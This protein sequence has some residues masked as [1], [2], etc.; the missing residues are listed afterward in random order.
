VSDSDPVPAGECPLCRGVKFYH[1]EANSREAEAHP[2]SPRDGQGHALVP[3]RICNSVDTR[4]RRLQAHLASAC[5]LKGEELEFDFAGYWTD[6][7]G[8]L[9][10]QYAREVL[11]THGWLTLDGNFGA[12]KTYLLCAIVNEA[13]RR[14]MLAVYSTMADLL[15]HLREAFKPGHEVEISF[16]AMWRNILSCP[17]LC[18]DEVEKYAATSWSEERVT[19]MLKDR[20]RTWQTTTTVLA[21][22]SFADCSGWLKS[23]MMDGRFKRVQIKRI[24]VRPELER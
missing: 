14:D 15:D 12:G 16:D 17:V 7:H 8:A 2:D 22:N 9:P 5:R 18:L 13:R 21:T 10:L 6:R 1:V 11:D 3:C 20:Y 24:D 19:A 23:L 4:Q